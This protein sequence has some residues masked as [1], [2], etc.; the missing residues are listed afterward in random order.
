[1]TPGLNPEAFS[2]AIR[3]AEAVSGILTVATTCV[4][5]LAAAIAAHQ[6]PHAPSARALTRGVTR[7]LALV[8]GGLIALFGI[9][10]VTLV[11]PLPGADRVLTVVALAAAP[12]LAVAGLSTR[13]LRRLHTAGMVFA[14]AP[15]TPVPPAL[16]AAAA[17][18]G[19][20][21]PVQV[22]AIALV[23]S[24]VTVLVAMPDAQL[25]R[26][27][28][29][30]AAVLGTMASGGYHV[31]RHSRLAEAAVPLSA[32]TTRILRVQQFEDRPGGFEPAVE[33][34][35]ARGVALGGQLHEQAAQD[36]VIGQRGRARRVEPSGREDRLLEV[37][38]EGGQG[39]GTVD[40]R[41]AVGGSIT[42]D[43][44]GVHGVSTEDRIPASGPVL[45]AEPVLGTGTTA[46]IV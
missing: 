25:L 18:P 45:A 37:A 33:P 4:V 7:L 35:R 24:G 2:I 44:F 8:I 22:T 23:T 16:R 12:A 1:M 17:H 31:L 46:E 41:V 27:A 28:L 42:S 30:A 5:W 32:H 36:G 43:D 9:G 39:R 14:T 11:S 20:A 19:V 34:L 15:R 13:R 26:P 6:L 21:V 40:D 29:T 10:L 38:V 3:Q